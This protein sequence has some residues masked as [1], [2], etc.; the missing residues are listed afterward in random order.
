MGFS[1]GFRVVYV[2]EVEKYF[3]QQ[4]MEKYFRQQKM[5]KGHSCCRKTHKTLPHNKKL[6]KV[7]SIAEN[8]ERLL[9]LQK[10]AEKFTA[11]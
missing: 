5:E 1:L 6:R 7:S 9:M 11:L 8:G 3:R 4:K 10:S 2:Q